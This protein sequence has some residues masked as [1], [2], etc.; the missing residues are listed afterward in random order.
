[1][2]EAILDAARLREILD[3]DPITGVFHWRLMLAHRRKPGDRAGNKSHGYIEIGIRNKSYRAHHLAWLYTYGE[4]PKEFIDHIDGNR[5]NNA[6]SNLRLATNQKNAQN[7]HSVSSSKIT[8]QYLGVTWNEANQCWMAQ[9]KHD[10]KN[11]YLGQYGTD[12]DAHLAY[13][14]AKRDLHD[15]ADICAVELPTPPPRI[16]RRRKSSSVNGVSY[17]NNR[18]KWCARPLVNGKRK[19]IGYF[20]SEEEAIEAVGSGQAWHANTTQAVSKERS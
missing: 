19:H 4:W 16:D 14:H 13:L 7:R 9:I 10:G 6:I 2:A 15:E 11:V 3:Y 18:K 8:S 5:S 20:A 12:F 1:M 17:D